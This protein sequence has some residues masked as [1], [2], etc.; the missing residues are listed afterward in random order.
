MHSLGGASL[1]SRAARRENP[2][3]A[4]YI[5]E[6]MV[7]GA[8]IIELR[9]RLTL[10]DETEAL[11]T[12]ISKGIDAG[13]TKIL[14]DLGEVTYIDSVGLSTLV[15][16]YTSVRKR[17]GGLKL[18]RMTGRV[19]DL[20]QITRLSTVFESFENLDAAIESFPSDPP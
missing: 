16:N 5:V 18:L 17:G 12:S 11:R 3:M 10:G 13:H 14:V 2:N 6:K 7:R 19:R 1:V 20:L 15:A 8:L 4:L 9:G